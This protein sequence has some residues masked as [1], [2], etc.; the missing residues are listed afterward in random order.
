M[1]S[2]WF[3][4]NAPKAAAPAQSNWFDQNAPG[5]THSAPPPRANFDNGGDIG[6]G[7]VRGTAGTAANIDDLVSRIPYVGKFLTTPLV[8]G[9]TSEQARQDLHAQA[10][11]Q[12][13]MQAL[14]RG[15][16]QTGEFMIPG[17]AEEAAGAKLATALPRA[18]GIAKA[19]PRV[20]SSGLV[21]KAQGGSFTGGAGAGIAGEGL[22]RG[23]ESAAPK[24][25]ESALGVRATDKI[26]GRTPG[27]AILNE[28]R[29]VRP[30]TVLSSAKQ[31]SGELIDELENR[32]A[33]VPSPVSL[34]GP[35]QIAA[36]ALVKAQR[37]NV[38]ALI[39]NVNDLA[40]VVNTRTLTGQAIP[41]EVPAMD[42]L[43]LKRGLGEYLPPGSWN[44]DTINR[45]APLRD[46]M[47]GSLDRALDQAAPGTEGINSRIASLLPV[48]RRAENAARAPGV[49]ESTMNRFRTPTGALASAL[50][51]GAEGMAHGGIPGAIAGGVFGAALPSMIASPTTQM[52][53]ARTLASPKTQ[54]LAR[55]LVRSAPGHVRR[56]EDDR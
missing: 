48:T 8:G 49:L 31:R 27:Q 54:G 35:R 32:I 44:P 24:F 9:K 47:Y 5:D 12:N 19:L 15:L 30:E 21:N 39:S 37:K 23:L 18:E 55:A 1:P 3:D 20:L 4:Q 56:A 51:L 2:N 13:D 40:N 46:Q 34:E 16:E 43:D 28:T 11:P 29:G 38:P 33:G 42:A 22:A 7:I 25:A 17:G 53:A 36:D 50:G 6:E 26:R 14:G 10:K 41:R 52:V 45:I